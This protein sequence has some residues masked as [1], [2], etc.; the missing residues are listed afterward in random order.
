MHAAATPPAA[1][2]PKRLFSPHLDASLHLV[3]RQLPSHNLPG[4]QLQV[5]VLQQR[6]GPALA[7]QRVHRAQRAH[8]PA[9]GVVEDQ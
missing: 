4:G 9:T 7:Q 5:R 8:T 1:T 6:Q 2:P 3:P